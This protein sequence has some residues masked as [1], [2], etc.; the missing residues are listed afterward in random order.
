MISG[1]ITVLQRMYLGYKGN[2][3]ILIKNFPR[4]KND[5]GAALEWF[6]LVQCN[7]FIALHKAQSCC[8]SGKNYLRRCGFTHSA[9]FTFHN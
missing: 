6:Y 3:K 2:A 7:K 9:L 1:V 8:P 5:I 4:L